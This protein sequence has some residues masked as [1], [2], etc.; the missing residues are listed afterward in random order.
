MAP[1]M[2]CTTCKKSK[3]GEIRSKTN[4]FKSK[5]CMYLGSQWIHMIPDGRFLPNY[6]EDHIAGRGDNSLQHYNLVHIFNL[7]PQAMQ[8]PAAKA[9]VD[10]EWEKIEKIPAWKLTKV[11][12][13]SEVIDEARTKGIKVHFAHWWTL[14]FEECRIGGKAPKIQRSSCTPRWHCERWFWIL[15]SIHRTRIISIT[16]D[17]SKSFG[18][19]IQTA[20]MRR[21]SS[22]RS[23]CLGQNGRCSKI[24]ENSKIGM[25]RHNTNGQNHGPV[26]KIQSFLLSGICMTIFWQDC[27]EKGNLRKSYCN[28]VGRR[29]P[30]GN[31]YSY[32]V[33][34]G[35]SYLCMWMT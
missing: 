2:L 9:A 19:H 15:C 12:S 1:A 30:I 14:S 28:T 8:I 27:Y 25:S 16:N 13:I 32:T 21:T 31:A 35:F 7:M 6:H 4:D 26:W 20:R 17:S 23:I 18:Y 22:W 11:R 5:I 34:K 24:I 3:K 33:K 10:D 29:F